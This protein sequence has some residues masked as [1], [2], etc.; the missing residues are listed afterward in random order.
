[1]S[2]RPDTP[3]NPVELE[4]ELFCRGLLVDDSARAG[5]DA[6]RVARTRAGLGSGVE[7]VIPAPRQGIWVNVPLDEPF[8]AASPL[9]LLR[10]GESFAVRDKRHP[11]V[12]YP[13]RLP[14]PPSWYART[15]ARG[16]PMTR[17]GVLQ[18]TYLGIYFAETCMY[19]YNT[20]AAASCQFCTTGVNVGKNEEVAKKVEDVVE[21]AK[22]AREESGVT[23][24][25]FNTGYHY[26][27]DAKRRPMHGPVQARAF[28]SAIRRNVGGFIGVQAVPV[29]REC[30]DE[31]DELI[32]LGCDHFSFCV[33]LLD[34]R[35]FDE[36]CPGKASTVG[37]EAFFEAMEYTAGK[38][39]RGRVSGEI[40]AGLEPI[41]ST[42]RA[43]DRIVGVGAFP[44][45]CI[46]RPLA[47][48]NLAHLPS[49]DPVEMREVMAYQYAAARREGLAVGIL[50][51]I[52][53]SLVVQP[54]EGRELQ[55]E[56]SWL[57]PYEW[58]LKALR[59][60]VRP[61]AAW[62]KRPRPSAPEF[63]PKIP[64]AT[65]DGN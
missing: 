46:F 45:V 16:V 15:T 36:V 27:D 52:K 24:T 49:P 13:V 14:D 61:W 30:W 57:D 35:W 48:S 63:K 55:A 12:V 18:G 47:G 50:P 29:L 1:M 28:V 58:K 3:W 43:I 54:E 42:K 33:E 10:E 22:V 17:V 60:L 25:H 7:L 8:V 51:N 23:F 41:E 34:K 26:E 62:K 53:V 31:Y 20:P 2:T 9:T 44:T 64:A 4:V 19:W 37:Q 38:L 11:D 32:E 40:I 6:R 65:A 56:K 21:V 59:T 39:G 5:V